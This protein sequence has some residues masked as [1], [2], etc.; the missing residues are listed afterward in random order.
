MGDT[1]KKRD[2]GFASWK[3][4]LAWMESM[5]GTQWNQAV[6]QENLAYESALKESD[7]AIRIEPFF[8]SLQNE[9]QKNRQKDVFTN[10]SIL[11]HPKRMFL[12]EWRYKD[13]PLSRNRKV[14]DLDVSGSNVWS[15]RDIGNGGETYQLEAF[16][17]KKKTQP[18]WSI[19]H[20]APTVGIQ[21]GRC[22]FLEADRLWYFRLVSVNAKTG[23][24]RKIHYE[25]K[26]PQWNLN[27]LRAQKQTLFLLGNKGGNEKLWE[28]HQGTLR[29]IYK[30]GQAF[31]PIHHHLVFV[32]N[33]GKNIY[34]SRGESI[35][36]PSDEQ[37]IMYLDSSRLL[38]TKY[39]GRQSI[40]RIMPN[41]KPALLQSFY[42]T[43]LFD[44]WFFTSPI[45]HPLPKNQTFRNYAK[46]S[47]GTH[48]PILHVMPKTHSPRGL[49]VVS[50]GAYGIPTPLKIER[51]EPLLQMGWVLAFALLRGGGDSTDDWAEQARRDQKRKSV[52]DLEACVIYLS[53]KLHF[54]PNQ[55]ALYGRSAGGY[56]V[57]AMVSR[58]AQGDLFQ[59]VYTEV[60]YVDILRTTTNPDLPLTQIEYEE[61]GDPIR[62]LQNF[63]EILRLSPVDTLSE[64]GAPGVFVLCRS[65]SNDLEVLAYESLKWIT[66]LKGKNGTGLPKLLALPAGEGHFPIS[67]NHLRQR[68][69]D[70]ALLDAW[71]SRLA[72]SN[73]K[74]PQ[75]I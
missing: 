75:R 63:G 22:F 48:V 67:E 18:S 70:L 12:V 59:M 30:D 33:P 47:D 25:E 19:Q 28:I 15:V 45:L 26:D 5:R 23:K 1:Q 43:I 56:V 46:S 40:W 55:I 50:Y 32:R 4:D 62:R 36:L 68:A 41:K 34:Q 49:L 38:F 24:N 29:P 14:A 42:G 16:L 51:W 10:G 11:I 35:P 7:V 3:N 54:S 8:Q 66:R 57:G 71:C 60:P 13:E 65:A 69:A 53:K 20:V 9:N 61:F 74:S 17:H 73:E 31:V 58:H 44:S 52:E 37:P 2:I 21:N 27:L 64:K 72:S 6:Q 39:E